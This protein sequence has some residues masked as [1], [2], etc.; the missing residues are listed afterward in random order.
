MRKALAFYARDFRIAT[1]YRTAFLIQLASIAIWVP[2]CF[3]ISEGVQGG[4]SRFLEKY[5]GD[6]FA[7]MLIGIGLFGYLTISLRTFNQSIRESQLMGTL[8]IVLL[9][10]TSIAQLLVYSSLWI[11][12]FA[13]IR[14]GVYLLIGALF[15]LELGN[16]NTLSALVVLLLSI[17]AFAS[18]GIGSA[19]VILVIKRGESLNLALATVSLVLAGVMFPTDVLPEWLQP[20]AKL[21]P[22]THSLDAMRLAL[23]QGATLAELGGH[24][25]ALLL[26]T[27]VVMPLSLLAFWKAVRW[28]KS[29]GTLAHY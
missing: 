17:P 19:S 20:A 2:I 6:Y 23:F 16:G 13:T 5:G 10:P 21:L 4:E 14:F 15:G 1:S 8:E 18:F 28:T 24:I 29:T 3:Y 26:F 7:F 11:Y 12:S 25:V 27:A 22:L 9:S